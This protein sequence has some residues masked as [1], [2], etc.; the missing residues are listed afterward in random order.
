MRKIYVFII[1]TAFA[2]MSVA[3]FSY[4]HNSMTDNGAPAV[5]SNWIKDG[6][7]KSDIHVISV[8]KTPTATYVVVGHDEDAARTYRI[9]Y[10][11]DE[12]IAPGMYTIV[13]RSSKFFFDKRDI[14]R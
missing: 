13:N 12:N 1:F 3:V 7:F 5:M 8:G 14:R 10:R 4:I 11:V 2:F 9:D 6:D